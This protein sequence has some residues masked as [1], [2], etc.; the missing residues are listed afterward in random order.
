MLKEAIYHR[1]KDNFAYAND[2]ESLHIMLKTKKDDLDTVTLIYGDPYDWIND[3]WQ[4]K[5]ANMMKS[6]STARHDYWFIEVKP[7]FRRMRY[8]F[9]C[10]NAKETCVYTERGFYAAAPTD[11][12]YY[13]CFPY[14]NKVDVFTAP[15]WVKDTVWYQVFP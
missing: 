1:P 14:L 11:T 3:N 4:M 15:E 8:G 10:S 9:R 2:D 7:E 13:F 6:G 12:A 5:T